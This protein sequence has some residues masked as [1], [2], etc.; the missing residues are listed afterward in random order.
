[1][2]ELTD[3]PLATTSGLIRPSSHGPQLEKLDIV[4]AEG[5]RTPPLTASLTAPTVRIFFESPL[6]VID[7]KPF[8][9]INSSCS[10]PAAQQIR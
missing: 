5:E 6:K 10:F 4:P 9:A 2:G 8:L 3:T 7:W 1:M